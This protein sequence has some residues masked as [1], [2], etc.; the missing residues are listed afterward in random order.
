MLAMRATSV[1]EALDCIGDDLRSSAAIFRREKP[2]NDRTT[3]DIFQRVA[4]WAERI[5]HPD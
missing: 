3:S 2:E 4:G 5:A 1:T